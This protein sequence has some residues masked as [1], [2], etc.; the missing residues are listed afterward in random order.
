MPQTH[1]AGLGGTEA[2]AGVQFLVKVRLALVPEPGTWVMAST[3]LLGLG[4]WRQRSAA[5]G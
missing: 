5:G 2:A 3:G 1:I 4:A